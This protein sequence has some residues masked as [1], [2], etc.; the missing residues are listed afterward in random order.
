MAL[1][2]NH[3]LDAIAQSVFTKSLQSVQNI[4]EAVAGYFFDH[5]KPAT[6]TYLF[7]KPHW[8]RAGGE[9]GQCEGVGVDGTVGNGEAGLLGEFV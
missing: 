5:R 4:R 6:R 2:Q 3:L 7:H 9:R 8:Q 1:S